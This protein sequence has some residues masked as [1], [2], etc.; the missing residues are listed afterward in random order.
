MTQARVKELELAW[1]AGFWD[2]EGSVGLFSDKKTKIL[3]AQLSHTE[4]GSI[5]RILE[6]LAMAEVDGRGYTYQ[7]R[8]PEKHRDAHYIRITGIANVLKLAKLLAPYAVTKLK[9]WEIVIEYAE[10]RIKKA[11]GIDKKGHLLRGGIA[12]WNAYSEREMELFRELCCLNRRGPEDRS[13]RAEGRI[14]AGL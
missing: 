1:L 10:S 5:I 9:H 6:I 11:G 4:F 7:E 8:N 13:R 3:V 2:G 14:N 12:G